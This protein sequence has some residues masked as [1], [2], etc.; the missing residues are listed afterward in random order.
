MSV[1]KDTALLHR[2]NK[3]LVNIIWGML[4]LGIVVDVLTG[5]PKESIFVLIAVGGSATCIATVMTYKRWFEQYVMYVIP[6][7]VTVLVLL[8]IMTGPYLSTYFLVF[9]NLAIMTLYGSFRAMA[10]TTLLSLILTVYLFISPYGDDMFKDDDPFIIIMYLALV[11]APLLASSKFSERVQAEVD[12]QRERA[13][14][15]KNLSQE[16][17][18][19]VTES[20]KTL[21]LFSTN[22]KDNVSSA[23]AI[24]HEITVAFGEVTAGIETQTDSIN[25]ISESIRIIE[26]SVAA[27]ATRSTDLRALSERSS[28]LTM[29]G[30]KETASL[31]QMMQEAHKTID[32]SVLLMNELSEQSK[33]ISEI[34]A[35]INNI[36]KQTNLLALNAAIEAARAGEHGKGFGVVSGEIRKL[37]ETSKESTE[38][39]V[40]ILDK[41][42]EKTESATEQVL[43]GQHSI[44]E[45]RAAS[46]Q[47]TEVMRALSSDA[48]KVE[49]QS[50]Q[51]ERAAD[52][53]H[54][55]YT[56]IA[57]EMVTIAGI[58]EEN[59]ASFEE[60]SASM[61]TQDSRISEIKQ[62][63]LQL[64]ELT[65][66]LNKM[67]QR[68]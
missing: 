59:M 1:F 21:N 44:N 47:V 6:L 65:Q 30:S 14:A 13:V 50:T 38:E 12:D 15:E 61:S 19:R 63:F 67:T 27:L 35:T 52:N 16:I 10:F 68:K 43:R 62:S 45:S 22:L 18:N 17:V 39:I 49:E 26:D 37:A 42:L 9:V 54:N 23:S 41:I 31:E 28:Q 11:V 20:L 32:S 60:M 33:Q 46:K 64:D 4:L 66:Q 58:T 8:L 5:V 7:I 48:A 56:K 29:Q 55:Q 57:D 3:L 36:S 25:G 53:L 24:S 51:V 40:I 34:V 2:R